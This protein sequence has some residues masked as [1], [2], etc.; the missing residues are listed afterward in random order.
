M[1]ELNQVTTY[2]LSKWYDWPIGTQWPHHSFASP[3]HHQTGT[4]EASFVPAIHI[5][6]RKWTLDV[7]L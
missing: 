5:F 4:E 1:L 2:H 6:R 7:P 3:A